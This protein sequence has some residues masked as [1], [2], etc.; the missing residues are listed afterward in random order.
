MSRS[1]CAV[2]S[3]RSPLH[4]RFGA[5]LRG[6]RRAAGLSQEAL[7]AEAGLHRT[8]ISLLERGLHSASLAAIEALA[9]VLGVAPHTLIEEAEA[10]P[11]RRRTA[12]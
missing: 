5:V 11:K 12:H 1:L 4:R 6:Q 9:G 8:Y 10:V 7:A 3:Q 2:A